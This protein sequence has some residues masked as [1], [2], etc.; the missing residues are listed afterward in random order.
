VSCFMS[1]SVKY[2]TPNLVALLSPATEDFCIH[3][4]GL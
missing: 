4:I 1:D 2:M 3:A